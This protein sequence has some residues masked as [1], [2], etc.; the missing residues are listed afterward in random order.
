MPTA[1]TGDDRITVSLPSL[2]ELA[3][4]LEDILKKLNGRLDD[5]YVI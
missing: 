5:L 3:Y 1:N 4:E 2:S